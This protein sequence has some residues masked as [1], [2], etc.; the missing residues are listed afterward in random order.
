MNRAVKS[1][2]YI[3]CHGSK[4]CALFKAEKAQLQITPL[5]GY[6]ACDFYERKDP[7]QRIVDVLIAEAV[8][9]ELLLSKAGCAE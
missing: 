2:H 6:P 3:G 5:H 9:A 4:H 1:C 8:D 7:Q